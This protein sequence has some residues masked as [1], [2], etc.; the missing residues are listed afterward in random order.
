MG[1]KISGNTSENSTIIIINDSNWSVETT[2][3][4]IIGSFDINTVFGKKTIVARN[5][6]GNI[7]AFGNIDPIQFGG[8]RGVFGGGN[9]G[10][11]TNTIFYVTISTIGDTSD[12]GDLTTSRHAPAS[13]SNGS[14]DRGV[15]AG[16]W[17]DITNDNLIDY[18]T[19]ESTS[20][21]SLFGYLAIDRG[22]S[23]ANSN[24]YNNRGL[25][26]GGSTIS[27]IYNVIEYITINTL[28]N[29]IDYGDIIASKRRGLGACSNGINDRGISAGGWTG[30]NTVN[31]IHYMTISTTGNTIDFGDLTIYSECPGVTSNDTN[32]R[33]V[34][35]G[36]RSNDTTHYN[37]ISYISIP[38][39]SNAADFGDMT[40]LARSRGSTSNGVNERGLFAG[41]YYT[42]YIDAIDYITIN[43]TGNA[44]SFGNMT[45]PTSNCDGTSN[46]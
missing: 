42:D 33:A 17:D 24:G 18:I 7:T 32:E 20:N 45:S 46:V 27:T 5:D 2:Q 43:T 44:L 37:V 21:S 14:N 3:S 26:I 39:T 11:Y 22:D 19:I 28:G 25:I 36:G 40:L 6:L 29:S 10:S 12:F 15:F 30:S 8:D 35:G 23:A 31:G 41:G 34:F 4:G 13:T 38:S 16:A 9:T 1:Y